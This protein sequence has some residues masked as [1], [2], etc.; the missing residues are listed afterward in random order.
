M[1]YEI[2]NLEKDHTLEIYYDEDPPNPR[3]EW[4]NLG[5]MIVWHS[6]YNLGDNDT[7]KKRPLSESYYSPEY[8][9][10]ELAN[11]DYDLLPG[12]KQNNDYL[13]DKIRK[14]H[15]ILPLYLYDHSGIT[16][17]CSRFSCPWD[18]GQVG[19]IYISYED[20][21]KEYNWKKLT[22]ERKD[23]IISYL[24]GEVETYDQYLT[25]DVYGFK[26]KDS[27]DNEIESYWGFYGSD[28]KTNGIKDHI[29][30]DLL[31]TI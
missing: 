30:Q 9:L 3:T 18:S 24:E 20:I 7:Y 5:T 15:I 16:I 23:K 22:K 28:W 12:E 10:A 1:L 4:D 8:F 21:R 11:V 25:G 26:I 27:E 19:W 6:R 2:I 31:K 14:N 13:L 29:A 17:S